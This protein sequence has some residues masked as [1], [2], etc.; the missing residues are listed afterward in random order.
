[1]CS[2]F[3]KQEKYQQ[4]EVSLMLTAPSFNHPTPYAL[5]LH[6]WGFAWVLCLQP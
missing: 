4:V 1:M 2:I 6:W 5:P 3:C